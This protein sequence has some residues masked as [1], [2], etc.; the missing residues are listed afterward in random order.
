[1]FG[2]F[3]LVAIKK[4]DCVFAQVTCNRPHTHKDYQEFS[5][6]YHNNGIEFWQFVH[7]DRKGW[8]TF[9][10]RMGMKIE[11]DERKK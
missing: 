5:R 3:D 10:Y 6:D 9:Q 4:G 7:Y 1:M 11:K 8:R 2:L